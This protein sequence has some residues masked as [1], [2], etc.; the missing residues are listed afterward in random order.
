M[1]RKLFIFV[2]FVA[3]V[4]SC[5]AWGDWV[6]QPIT[7]LTN[8]VNAISLLTSTATQIAVVCDGG[9]MYRSVDGGSSW[10]AVTT[11]TSNDLNDVIL[12]SATE[13]YLL[14]DSGTILTYNFNTDTI[15]TPAAPSSSGDFINITANGT[16]RAVVVSNGA[17]T[18]GSLFTSSDS[19]SSWGAAQTLTGLDPYGVFF[20]TDST[21]ALETWIWGKNFSTTPVQ[22]EIWKRPTGG[23]FSVVWSGSTAINDLRWAQTVDHIYAVGAGGAALVTTDGGSTWNTLTTGV[24]T[25]LFSLFFINQ[26]FGWVTGQRGTIAHTADGG[27]DWTSYFV[28]GTLNN[29]NDLD[30]QYT[31]T[32]GQ[33]ELVFAYAVGDLGSVWKLTSPT[34]TTVSPTQGARG[35]IFSSAESSAIEI[36]GTGFLDGAVVEFKDATS[37]AADANIVVFCTSFESST[38]LWV[39]AWISPEA[40][41]GFRDVQVTNPDSTISREA[42]GFRVVAGIPGI[43]SWEPTW[44][45]TSGGMS[46]V[47]GPDANGD[48]TTTLPPVPFTLRYDVKSTAGITIASCNAALVV[49]QQGNYNYYAI[50][51]A[52]ISQVDANTLRINTVFPETLTSGQNVA[53]YKYVQDDA[54]NTSSDNLWLGVA[55]TGGKGATIIPGATKNNDCF[56]YPGGGTNYVNINQGAVIVTRIPEGVSLEDPSA[57]LTDFRGQRIWYQKKAGTFVNKVEWNIAAGSINHSLKNSAGA[58]MFVVFDRYNEKRSKNVIMNAPWM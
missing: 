30:V 16:N 22:Y 51:A 50:P 33:T 27:S 46:V 43:I 26:N 10:S 42:D 32:G 55:T 39:T 41:V 47:T 8:N 52:D 40:A 49:Y 21:G 5:A 17:S 3:I 31:T 14:G 29:V 35:D 54:G 58:L 38:K 23:G 56:T 28:G 2:A 12:V 45:G 57:Y 9:L 13:G 4:C 44:V 19:G 25:D 48:P 6:S 11:G 37:E 1:S 7:G 20:T 53:I 24:T 34:I 15:A 36:T 18:A